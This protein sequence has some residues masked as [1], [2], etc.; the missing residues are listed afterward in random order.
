MAAV[1]LISLDRSAATESVEP[2]GTLIE[3]VT[4]VASDQDV[5]VSMVGQPTTA[6]FAAEVLAQ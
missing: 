1:A 5:A 2:G 6:S 4:G 3:A